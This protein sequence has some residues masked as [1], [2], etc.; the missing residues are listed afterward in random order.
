MFCKYE[1]I[2]SFVLQNFSIIAVGCLC[3]KKGGNS[4]LMAENKCIYTH[5]HIHRN[6]L[7]CMCLGLQL[8]Y[9]EINLLNLDGAILGMGFTSP[10]FSCLQGINYLNFG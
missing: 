9:T 10:V 6:M 1:C 4:N 7:K 8:V 3:C 2:K 5:S